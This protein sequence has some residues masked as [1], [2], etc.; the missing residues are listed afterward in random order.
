M[1]ARS[2]GVTCAGAAR[3]CSALRSMAACRVGIA[4]LTGV[5]AVP[6]V[7]EAEVRRP[8]SRPLLGLEPPPF[9]RVGGVRVDNLVETS[10]QPSKGAASRARRP[11]ARGASSPLALGERQRLG[12]ARRPPGAMTRARGRRPPAA[13]ASASRVHRALG[14][15]AE[16]KPHVGH[17]VESVSAWWRER[18]RLRWRWQQSRRRRR[19]GPRQRRPGAG[20]RRSRLSARA[21][22]TSRVP[23]LGRR[24]RP[25]RG[26]R[27]GCPGPRARAHRTRRS[28]GPASAAGSRTCPKRRRVRAAVPNRVSE[29]WTAFEPRELWM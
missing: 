12:S 4:E 2:S 6:V 10:R 15:R 28:G 22:A 23:L 26:V 8:G 19:C 17:G 7:R 11:G 21:R 3:A 24:H 1:R 25:G 27:Q 18:A 9:G 14:L 29:W 13:A 16:R 20:A 5:R